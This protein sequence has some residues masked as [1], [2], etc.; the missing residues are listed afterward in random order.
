MRF[1]WLE[2]KVFSVLFFWSVVVCLICFASY[3]SIAVA[4]IRD[5]Y[6]SSSANNAIGTSFVALLVLTMPCLLLVTFGMAIHC[7]FAHRSPGGVK[8]MWFL[9]FLVTWPFG[10]MV[11]YFTVYRRSIQRKGEVAPSDPQVMSV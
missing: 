7:A 11:Y 3:S 2:S 8:A 4:W 1:D 10:S 9:L 5:F 6:N